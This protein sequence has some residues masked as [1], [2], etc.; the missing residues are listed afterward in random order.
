MMNLVKNIQ[1]R[2][3]RININGEKRQEIGFIH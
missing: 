2:R 1:L 3:E